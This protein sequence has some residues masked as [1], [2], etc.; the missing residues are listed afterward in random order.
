MLK[1]TLISMGAVASLAAVS[2]FLYYL[3]IKYILQALVIILCW[4]M[5]I[6]ASY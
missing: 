5:M 4:I 6:G 2:G 3:F 1:K